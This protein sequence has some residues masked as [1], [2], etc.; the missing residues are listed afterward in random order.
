MAVRTVVIL[1]GVEWLLLQFF[2]LLSWQA[3]LMK[4][5]VCWSVHF[6]CMSGWPEFGILFQILN[7]SRQ[8]SFL[9]QYVPSE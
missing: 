5:A 4:L 6:P 1:Q 2:I 7:E 9:L 8:L 3:T